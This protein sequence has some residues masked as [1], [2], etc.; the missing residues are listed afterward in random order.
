MRNEGPIL[1]LLYITFGLPVPPDS[2]AR[3]RDFNLIRR[4]GQ[5]HQVSVLSL[6]EFEDELQHAEDL[7]RFCDH[8]DGVVI[9]RSAFATAKIALG[10]LFQQRPV[11]TAPFYYPEFAAKI[12]KL[13]QHQHFDVVQIEHSFLAPYRAALAPTF[14]GVTVLSMHNIGVQQYRSILDMSAG[15]SRIPAALKCWLMRDWE[16]IAANRFQHVITVSDCD[17]DRLL[18]LGVTANISVIGNGVDC[19]ALQP[20]ETPASGTEEIIFIGTMGYLPNRDAAR[21]LAREIFPLIRARKPACQLNLVGS[22]G[23]E[24]LA[25]LAEPGRVNVTGRVEDP[26][27]YY[28]RSK[29]AVVPLRSGG[30]SRL[31]ILEAMALGR[32][33][34][35]TTLGREGLNLQD[36]LDVLTAD[37]PQTFANYVVELL[38]NE[39]ARQTYALAGRARVEKD[40]DWNIL[41]DRLLQLYETLVESRPRP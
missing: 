41:A 3:L 14:R 24:Y 18:E 34:V 15:I 25:D 35:S 37:D 1:N 16:V 17:R 23:S 30:G 38:E 19:T 20:L 31:K 33:V 39:A 22:G 29:L 40:Y 26:I 11:A 27:P 9:H 8:V 7:K 13:T 10:S 32:P 12:S 36:G 5:H 21:Y 4:V 28:K 6:L 2:G